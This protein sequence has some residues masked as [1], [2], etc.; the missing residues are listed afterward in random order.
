MMPCEIGSVLALCKLL[1]PGP[2][3]SV[4]IDSNTSTKLAVLFESI[5]WLILS[6]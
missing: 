3:S 5:L 2:L 4:N 1:G 6:N